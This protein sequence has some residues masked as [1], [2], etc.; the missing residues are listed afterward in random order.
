M[1]EHPCNCDGD[2][3]LYF[4]NLGECHLYVAK[5]TA[6]VLKRNRIA[7]GTVPLF[8]SS[9]ATF[10]LFSLWVGV[11]HSLPVKMVPGD[12]YFMIK[13]PE[14]TSFT[15]YEKGKKTGAILNKPTLKKKKN[16]RKVL[17]A[18][19]TRKIPSICQQSRGPLCLKLSASLKHITIKRS[20]LNQMQRTSC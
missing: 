12:L 15:S 9:S 19:K 2:F 3:F 13:I 5:L 1:T 8:L 18:A 10:P 20:C 11:D 6:E 16:Q 14:P 7:W 17:L 4:N